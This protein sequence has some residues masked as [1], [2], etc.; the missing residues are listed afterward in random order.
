MI[1]VKCG[2]QMRMTEKDTSS[3]REF[4]NTL[5]RLRPHRLG[6]LRHGP[7]A[8]SARRPEKKPKAAK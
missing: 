7:L 3:G 6:S 4:A 1:C 8:D 5:R 2:E